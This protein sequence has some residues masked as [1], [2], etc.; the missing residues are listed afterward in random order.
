METN[1][2]NNL[3][4]AKTEKDDEF[5]TQFTDIEKE[6]KHY[7]KHFKNKVVYCNCDDPEWSNFFKYF[8]NAFDYLGLKK[9]IT[10]HYDKSGKSSYKLELLEQG[11]I[12][13]TKL[14][15]DGDFRSEEC[16][17]I[18]KAADIVVTNPPFSLLREYIKQLIDFD[19]KFLIIGTENAITYKEIFPLL[20]DNK[21]WLGINKPSSFVKPN[22][23][24]K[25]FGN[26]GWFSNLVHEK[27]NENVI[28]YKSYNSSDYCKYDNYDAIEVSKVVDI[29]KDYSGVMGVPIS[30]MNKYNPEQFIIVGN[31]YTENIKKGRCYVNGKRKFSRV[32]IQI[33]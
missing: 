15:G 14:N 27:R 23:D 29:P 22:G 11:K 26:I 2:N 24:I 21:M 25:K 7:K 13:K 1:K 30:F 33:K 31:E 20:R 19:K 5:Y 32:L 3:N 9:L 8:S 28:L 17:D 12:I 4:K 16:I 6:I 10:T 18:L